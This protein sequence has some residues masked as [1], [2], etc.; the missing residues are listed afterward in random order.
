MKANTKFFIVVSLAVLI[1]GCDIFESTFDKQVNACVDDVK[2]GLG[3]PDSL[4]ITSTEGIDVN[5][6]W[7]RIKL[8]FTAKNAMGGRVRGDAICGFIDKNSIELNE[9]DPSNEMRK[10]SRDLRSLGIN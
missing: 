9:K 1:Q 5:N 8:N 4:E 7:F 3:D 2:L 6:G 10:L